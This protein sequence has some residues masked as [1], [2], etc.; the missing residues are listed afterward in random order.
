MGL[1]RYKLADGVAPYIVGKGNDQELA[2][3][4]N[5]AHDMVRDPE[6]LAVAPGCSRA[7]CRGGLSRKDGQDILNAGIKSL[8][9]SNGEV[10]SK[11]NNYRSCACG[12]EHR[13]Y[14]PWGVKYVGFLSL[15]NEG[16][17]ILSFG[18]SIDDAHIAFVVFQAELVHV[19]CCGYN[20]LVFCQVGCKDAALRVV[21]K[22][23]TG[24]Q[25][26]LNG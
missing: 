21:K 2:N 7:S 12:T 15:V 10:R 24:V 16:I 22:K 1:T 26:T 8:L 3:Q 18:R 5:V 4:H 23:V 13:G 9:Q 14:F 11:G 20:K 19:L 6:A 25:A 17:K